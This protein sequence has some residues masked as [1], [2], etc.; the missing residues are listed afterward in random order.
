[1]LSEEN[2]EFRPEISLEEFKNW[3]R[4]DKTLPQNMGKDVVS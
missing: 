2:E 4:T 3:I 1:M